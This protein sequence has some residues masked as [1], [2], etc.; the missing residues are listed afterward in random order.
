MNIQ[1]LSIV[2][3]TK[4][5]WN[6]CPYCVSHMHCED[7][8]NYSSKT[9]EDIITLGY[10]NRMKFVRDQGCNTLM[11]TG[12]AEPQQNMFFIRHLLAVNAIL[13]NPFYNIEFQ[14]TGSGMT[15]EMI[16]ELATLG[17][18]TLALSISSLDPDRNAEIIHMP[19]KLKTNFLYL[20][21]DAHEYGMNV[22]A[23]LNLTDE[24]HRFQPEQYIK[25]AHDL[26]IEQLTF[27]RIAETGMVCSDERAWVSAHNMPWDEFQKIP[28]Y[29]EKVGTPIARLPFGYIKYSIRDVSVVVDTNCLAKDEIDNFK[30]AILRPNGKLYSRWDDKGS[31]IF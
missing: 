17:V 2:V 22:R 24:F 3:P 31:L 15:T 25:W 29:I 7:Y 14:T 21:M 4:A 1:S 6:H 18:T 30:Y 16:K 12:T 19:E 10:I 9:A 26:G 8:G 23:C 27:R 11:I 13:P 5:C 20:I 28:A